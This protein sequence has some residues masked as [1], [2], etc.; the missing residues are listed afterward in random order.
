MTRTAQYSHENSYETINELTADTE[1]IWVC[2]HG[3][4][5]LA[6]YFK[7]YFQGFNPITNYIIVLQA[8]SKYYQDSQFKNVG[9]SWL[10]R[11]N[12]QQEIQNNFRYVDAVL[13]QE[14][15]SG[16]RRVVIFG[17]SQ[18]VSMAT[19]YLIHYNDNAKA[20]IL[21]SGSIPA[22]LNENDGEIFKKLAKRIIHISGKQD[23]Y[24]TAER[25]KQE[26]QKIEMLF[27]TL[28]EKYRPD[29]NHRVDVPLLEKLSDQL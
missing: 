20:L 6:T 24:A 25:I 11:V 15:L 29:I 14:N 22:E 23:E 19:R 28:C 13:E 4:G 10:T 9:A 2:F 16:D 5:Y 3:L 1:N 26:E 18:G 8:P 27:G 17:Y 21:H 12:T 7:K